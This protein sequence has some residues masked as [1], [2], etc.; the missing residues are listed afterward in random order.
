MN[1]ATGEP[2]APAAA[3]GSSRSTRSLAAREA[4][5]ERRRAEAEARRLSREEAKADADAIPAG[6]SV[7]TLAEW[8]GMVEEEMGEIAR[9]FAFLVSAWVR[10]QVRLWR[11]RF[12]PPPKN[13]AGGGY[14]YP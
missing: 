1:P 14:E 4:R 8:V 9:R 10:L 6:A 2:I 11:A 5:A 3:C 7:E 12:A 13:N